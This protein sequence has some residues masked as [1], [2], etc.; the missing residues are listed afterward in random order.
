MTLQLG[1]FAGISR[2]CRLGSTALT[3]GQLASLPSPIDRDRPFLEVMC[4]PIPRRT[5]VCS[6]RAS[7]QY[8]S[9]SDAPIEEPLASDRPLVTAFDGVQSGS[10]SFN[11]KARYRKVA[12]RQSQGRRRDFG[13]IGG[14]C[15]ENIFCRCTHV[16]EVAH[17]A[18]R[19]RQSNRSVV[20]TPDRQTAH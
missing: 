5:E 9:P 17:D 3:V 16:H 14:C 18:C 4:P 1:A 7:D 15:Q 6:G 2:R 12:E 11:T 8:E 20:E 13:F 19:E 10:M